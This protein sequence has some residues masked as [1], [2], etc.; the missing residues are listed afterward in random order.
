MHHP[1]VVS[2][3]TGEHDGLLATCQ[4]V[5]GE[6]F[7]GASC[8]AKAVAKRVTNKKFRNRLEDLV[9]H[10]SSGK[11]WLGRSAYLELR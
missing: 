8:T 2:F 9:Q 10:Q 5:C 6:L 7:D 4:P 1:V 3:E 11:G